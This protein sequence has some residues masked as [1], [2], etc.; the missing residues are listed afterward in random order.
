MIMWRGCVLKVYS[1]H[2]VNLNLTSPQP[3][4]KVLGKHVFLFEEKDAKNH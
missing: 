4:F 2:D 3:P 1:P